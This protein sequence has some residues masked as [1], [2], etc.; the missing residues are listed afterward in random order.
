[1]NIQKIARDLNQLGVQIIEI[2]SAHD[3]QHFKLY[4]FIK[5]K[6]LMGD[7]DDRFKRVFCSFYVMNGARGLKDL[8]KE[9]FF[10]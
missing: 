7:F 6:F 9:K 10:H 5:E 3:W 4:F 2:L 8:Q 1:M